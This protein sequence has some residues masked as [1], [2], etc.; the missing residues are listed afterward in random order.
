ML[1]QQ[2]P[3]INDA[4]KRLYLA[5]EDAQLRKLAFDIEEHELF[6]RSMNHRIETL[7]QE[8]A[9]MAAAIADKDAAI[10]ELK[11]LLIANGIDYK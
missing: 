8:N 7:T 1:A 6:I 11:A 4:A 2:D 10:A 3:Y 9:D 5:N